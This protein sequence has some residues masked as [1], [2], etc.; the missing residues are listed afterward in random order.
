MDNASNRRI[1]RAWA[2]VYDATF[3]RLL[4]GGRR[5]TI[6]SLALA[7]GD[8]LLVPGVGTGL[9]LPLIPPGVAVTG[10]DLSPEML[11]RARRRAASA[12]LRVA[13]AQSLAFPDGSFDAVLCT[14]ILSVVPDGRAALA[15]AWRVLRPGGRLAIYD[16]FLR[17]GGRPR[18][19]DR[20]VGA[21]ASRLGTDVNRRLE[22]LMA[23]LPGATVAS[24]RPDALR[25]RY[26]TILLIKSA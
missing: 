1:Y 2:P 13:D 22:D 12:D 5:R 23:G 6:A 16:K 3:G 24:D 21:V 18:R 19:I 25:G 20:A 4:R 11:A 14:L 7:P 26:R 8:R 10:I 9:D 15:E 17:S